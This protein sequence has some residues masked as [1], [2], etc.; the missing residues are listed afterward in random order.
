MRFEYLIRKKS[1][2]YDKFSYQEP[3]T[4]SVNGTQIP[5]LASSHM[6]YSRMLICKLIHTH[7]SM[8][9]HV[10]QLKSVV[11]HAQLSRPVN[12]STV[13]FSGTYPVTSMH[14]CFLCVCCHLQSCHP[15]MGRLFHGAFE[16]RLGCSGIMNPIPCLNERTSISAIDSIHLLTW[17]STA[18]TVYM[19]PCMMHST[20]MQV[21]TLHRAFVYALTP[22]A[23]NGVATT[24]W[25]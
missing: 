3:V 15:K 13:P 6:L 7:R 5:A 17:H 25:I 11:K 4:L 18:Q 9:P 20:H 8:P 1:W 10:I 21:S 16:S 2:Y 14:R 12:G 23:S 24:N 22:T 19:P